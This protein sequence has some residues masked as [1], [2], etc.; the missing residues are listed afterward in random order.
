MGEEKNKTMAERARRKRRRWHSHLVREE[1]EQDRCCSAD[2]CAVSSTPVQRT[3]E[4]TL[5]L[6]FSVG[7]KGHTMQS[8]QSMASAFL[9]ETFSYFQCGE[10]VPL[11][12]F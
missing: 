10:F 2:V 11:P 4:R 6:T 8:P 12:L 1:G 5:I 9:M 3:L 7:F